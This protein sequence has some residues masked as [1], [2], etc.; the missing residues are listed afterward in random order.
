MA[1]AAAAA[2]V[3]SPLLPAQAMEAILAAGAPAATGLGAKLLAAAPFVSAGATGAGVLDQILAQPPGVPS[4]GGL[5]IPQPPLGPSP[6]EVAGAG[7]GG[8]LL[9][10]ELMQLL[11]RLM[12]GPGFGR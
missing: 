9:S 10:P 8:G 12:A 5:G 2:P 1:G 7:G 11:S 3:I 6:S 4:P